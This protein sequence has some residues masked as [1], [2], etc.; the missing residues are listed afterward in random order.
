M[1][2]SIVPFVVGVMEFEAVTMGFEV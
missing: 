1:H 2:A